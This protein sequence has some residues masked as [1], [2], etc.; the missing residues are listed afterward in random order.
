[1]SRRRCP[2]HAFRDSSILLRLLTIDAF[3]ERGKN[4]EKIAESILY[5]VQFGRQPGIR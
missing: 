4:P 3:I 2:Q 5:T 1:M